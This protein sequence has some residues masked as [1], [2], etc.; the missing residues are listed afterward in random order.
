MENEPLPSD[1]TDETPAAESDR[2]AAPRRLRALVLF[3]VV[4]AVGLAGDL[5]TKHLLFARLGLPGE[6]DVDWV[7]PNIFGFQ[8]S[9]NQG[10]LFGMGQNITWFF[11][12]ASLLALAVVLAWLLRGAYRH[13]LTTV[14]LGG[15]C[16]GILG[17]LW[18]RLALHGLCYPDFVDP[19]LA[20]KPIHAVRDWILVMIGSWP[21]PNF[22]LAD[23]FLV[24]GVAVIILATLFQPDKFSAE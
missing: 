21:W 13:G 6:S 5:W 14:A 15:I 23:T 20:G 10:A 7:I 4:A 2:P 3:T 24:C 12:V 22:N 16:A 18:D 19:A 9:L 8:T 1:H 17:N 11:S